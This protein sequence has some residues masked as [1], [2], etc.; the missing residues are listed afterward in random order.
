MFIKKMID[1]LKDYESLF[2]GYM[3][4][5]GNFYLDLLYVW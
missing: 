3:V 2:C 4:I 1:V 5:L